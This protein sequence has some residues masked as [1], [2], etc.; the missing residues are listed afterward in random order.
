M[1]GTNYLFYNVAERHE[2]IPCS[3]ITRAIE[4]VRP[5]E[6]M[7]GYYQSQP[8]ENDRYLYTLDRRKDEK[9]KLLRESPNGKRQLKKLQKDLSMSL[10]KKLESPEAPPRPKTPEFQ[11]QAYKYAASL[12]VPG[13]QI[14]WKPAR[15]STYRLENTS[16]DGD[17]QDQLIARTTMGSMERALRPSK[18]DQK[19]HISPIKQEKMKN[20][21]CRVLSTSEVLH[22]WS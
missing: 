20:S 9:E 11:P 12:N 5:I 10:L 7:N 3:K 13:D 8:L 17:I 2:R 19:F 18:I 14:S 6:R 15:S 22:R 4:S 16:K 21:T 1:V